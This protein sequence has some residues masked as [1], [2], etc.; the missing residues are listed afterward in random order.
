[1]ITDWS[2]RDVFEFA[3]WAH[4]GQERKFSGEPYINHPVRVSLMAT[5]HGLGHIQIAAALLHDLVEDCDVSLDEIT[6]R[7]GRHVANVVWGLTNYEARNGGP[8]DTMNRA[9]RKAADRLWLAAQS[10]GVKSLKFLDMIDNILDRPSADSF[11]VVMLGEL[12]LLA[13]AMTMPSVD[14]AY[15]GVHPDLMDRFW[16]VYNDAQEACRAFTTPP[17]S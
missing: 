12:R 15:G 8:D 3:K 11:M 13:D 6:E 5:E 16:D 14:G 10:P 4:I 17:P 1:M 2:M 9:E 7:F